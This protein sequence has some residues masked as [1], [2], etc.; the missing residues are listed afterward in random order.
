[1]MEKDYYTILD[2]AESATIEEIKHAYR[3]GALKF[4]PDKNPEE[5]KAWAHKKFIELSEAYAVLINP[6]KRNEF[7]RDRAEYTR[8]HTTED[9]INE[10]RNDLED[11]LKDL[12]RRG[13]K[14]RADFGG[15]IISQDGAHAA[16]VMNSGSSSITVNGVKLNFN[17]SRFQRGKEIKESYSGISSIFINNKTGDIN[18]YTTYSDKVEVNGIAASV[19]KNGSSLDIKDLEGRVGLNYASYINMET[20]SG[21]IL[22]AIANEGELK[23]MSGDIVLTI[24]RPLRVAAETLSGDINVNGLA[25]VNQLY[26]PLKDNTII[27]ADKIVYLNTMSGDIRLKYRPQ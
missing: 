1:M 8:Q 11:I 18:L 15:V 13:I 16:I 6:L 27:R 10:G 22:G 3:K 14:I 19:R 7:N 26:C 12:E 24:K 4:H 17:G 2:V 23:T 20:M 9:I 5:K 21:D 25:K